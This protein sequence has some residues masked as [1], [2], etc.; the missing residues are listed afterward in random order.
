[1]S[2]VNKVIIIGNLGADPELKTTPGGQSVCNFSVATSEKFESKGEKQEKTEWHKMVAWGKTA[3]L[4][5]QYLRKGATAYFD[6]KLQTRQWDKDGVKH[7]ATEIVVQSVTFLG[8]KRDDAQPQQQRREPNGNTRQAT[9]QQT[10]RPVG[11]EYAP[12]PS[13]EFP[14]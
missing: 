8:G 13:D 4:I 10:R 12:P 7:Y 11:H 3:E 6:G 2:G 9:Q 14:Y 5:A 1:M